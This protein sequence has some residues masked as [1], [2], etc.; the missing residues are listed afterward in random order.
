MQHPSYDCNRL[1]AMLALGIGA[2]RPAIDVALMAP[3]ESGGFVPWPAVGQKQPPSIIGEPHYIPSSVVSEPGTEDQQAVATR[4]DPSGR[5]AARP[6][7]PNA[8]REV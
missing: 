6:A 1:E 7:K 3:G 5:A 4:F 2:G 8:W